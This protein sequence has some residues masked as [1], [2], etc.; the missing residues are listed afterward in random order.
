MANSK[1]LDIA[2]SI[3]QRHFKTLWIII[4]AI[5]TYSNVKNRMYGGVGEESHCPDPIDSYNHSV[6]IIMKKINV[7]LVKLLQFLVFVIFTFAVLSYFSAMILLPLALVELVIEFLGLFTI[8]SLIAALVA[9]VVVG[10]L[11]F[12]AY[13]I[14]GL[15][16]MIIDI[17]IDLATIGKARVEAFNEI[18]ENAKG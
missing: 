1:E 8:S 12:C 13:K 17:G 6:K 9:V 5:R 10:Y 14:P 18:A 16:K 3:K 2:Q 11:T 15:A 4:G 7:T